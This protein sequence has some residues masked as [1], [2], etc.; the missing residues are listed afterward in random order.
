MTDDLPREV[1][2]GLHHAR[3]EA[4]RRKSRLRVC[5]GDQS[6]TLLRHWD[7][8]FAMAAD[9][10]RMRGLVDIY[11]GARHLSQC[12]IVASSEEAGERVYDFKRSTP[13][14]DRPA[15]DYAADETAP[16]GLIGPL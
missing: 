9:A 16:V 13:A 12:L 7:R 4:Q 6:F 15:R 3:H 11:D 10:P 8:G 5:I 2:E 1:L 14:S